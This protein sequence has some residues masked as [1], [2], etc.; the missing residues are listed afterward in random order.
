M[1]V[2]KLCSEPELADGY[3][4]MVCDK[5]AGHRGP[6]SATILWGDEDDDYDLGGEG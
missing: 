3:G 1:D 6:H 4:W 2:T 5:P